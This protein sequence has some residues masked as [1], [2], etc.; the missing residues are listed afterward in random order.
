M[1]LRKGREGEAE[2]S[3]TAQSSLHP[4]CEQGG[5]GGLTAPAALTL[6]GSLE[7]RWKPASPRL[8]LHHPLLWVLC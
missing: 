8:G 2:R 1:E 3:R 7:L 6:Q 4:S 5:G